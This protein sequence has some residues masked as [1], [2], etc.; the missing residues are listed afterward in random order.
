MVV[1]LVFL[2]RRK[3]EGRSEV[4]DQNGESELSEE[5]FPPTSEFVSTLDEWGGI[6]SGVFAS[7]AENVFGDENDEQ[8]ILA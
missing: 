4:Q 1:V 2:R 6:N 3:S 5:T 8:D 7:H